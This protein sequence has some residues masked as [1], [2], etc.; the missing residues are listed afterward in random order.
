M[1][2]P[3]GF[4]RRKAP[5]A[6]LI[7][8]RAA[9]QFAVVININVIGARRRFTGIGRSGIVRHAAVSNHA[10][11]RRDIIRQRNRAG[12]D[13]RYRS[14][15]Y[16]RGE[17]LP[18]GSSAT[19]VAVLSPLLIGLGW[20]LQSPFSSAVTVVVSPLSLSVMVTFAPGS[21]LPAS[22]LSSFCVMLGVSGAVSS[23]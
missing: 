4:C 17:T 8:R 6:I 1:T 14:V 18:A 16:K 15:D 20:M 5:V 10:G 13:I 19:T 2:L 9:N 21:A 7:H 3:P 12:D 22:P 23:R 11:N